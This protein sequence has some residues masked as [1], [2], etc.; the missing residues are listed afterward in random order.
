MPGQLAEALAKAGL[1]PA[2]KAEAAKKALDHQ[3][4]ARGRRL[5]QGPI[6]GSVAK[7]EAARWLEA[8]NEKAP[9]Q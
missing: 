5:H 3:D 1:V 2:E 8:A 4:A 7:A 6:I 9:D